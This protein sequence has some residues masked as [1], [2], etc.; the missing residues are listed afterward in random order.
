MK[1][2]TAAD[3]V[4]AEDIREGVLGGTEL[5][6]TS[7]YGQPALKSS[8]PLLNIFITSAPASLGLKL[9]RTMGHKEGQGIGAKQYRADLADPLGRSFLLAPRDSGI[10]ELEKKEN[11]FGLGYDQFEAAPEFREHGKKGDLRQAPSR[12]QRIDGFGLGAFEDNDDMEV[13]EKGREA[14]TSEIIDEEPEQEAKRQVPVLLTRRKWLPL[15]LPSQL[16]PSF[17]PMACLCCRDFIYQPRRLWTRSGSSR[18]Q[19]PP[20]SSRSMCLRRH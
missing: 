9:L 13:Y 20:P 1:S 4:D 12:R 8:D 19:C 15:L 14:Y 5:V 17:A 11:V 2:Q 3:F 10:Y 7:E 16:A 6:N 18:P